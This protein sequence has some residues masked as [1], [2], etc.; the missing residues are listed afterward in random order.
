MVAVVGAVAR[1]RA[2]SALLG[3]AF[4]AAIAYVDP[5][6]FATNMAA[7]SRYGY[8]LLWVVVAANTVA[9]LVQYLSAK[10]G[11]VAGKSL[12]EVVRDR[13]SRPARL[14]YWAQ[15]ELVAMSTDLAEMLGGA[16]A[17]LLLF[18]LPLL[19]GGVLTGLVSTGLLLVR[20]RRS[21]RL[22]ERVLTTLLAVIAVGFVVGL[23][24]APPSLPEAA[25]GIVPQFKGPDSVLLVGGILGA[26]VMPHVI[27][28]HSALA[29]DRHGRLA[30]AA[31][32]RAL[33]ATRLDVVLAMAFAGAVNIA[34]LLLAAS[35]LRSAP[36]AGRLDGAFA[37]IDSLLGSGVAIVFAVGLL[38]SGIASTAVGSYSGATVVED[39]LR[40]RVP[41]LVRRLIT[42]V[43]AFV[44]LALGVDPTFVLLLSQVVL[45]FGIPFALIPLV[46]LTSARS[47]MGTEVNRSATAV[48]AWAAAAV[49]IVLNL[50]LIALLFL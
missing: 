26:T 14:A 28:L 38:A 47:L 24:V 46:R 3:P 18:E 30:G 42:V 29:R 6:N 35:A 22:F 17:L 32:R 44:L 8:L 23:F 2:G 39:L 19:L 45:S 13:L 25:A 49:I 21:Q 27:Y 12:P 5:G 4:V 48:L 50:I 37:A 33:T 16:I 40:V 9:G 36:D 10:L 31:L 43:P 15:A 34:M 41:L 1:F 20:D 11:L 7:G